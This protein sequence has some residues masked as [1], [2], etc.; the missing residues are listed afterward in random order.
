MIELDELLSGHS[1][2][3]GK[4]RGR[5]GREEKKRRKLKS[6]SPVSPVLVSPVM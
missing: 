3:K 5:K 4:E 6:Y 2:E 1:T